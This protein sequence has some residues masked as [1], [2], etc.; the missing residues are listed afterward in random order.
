M[1]E[2][3]GSSAV[4]GAGM[5]LSGVTRAGV[6]RLFIMLSEISVLIGCSSK[7]FFIKNSLVNNLNSVMLKKYQELD[8]RQ[9]IK[10]KRSDR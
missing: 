7:T 5:R 6:I 2:A 4:E 10:T 9:I 1:R 3:F 8:K